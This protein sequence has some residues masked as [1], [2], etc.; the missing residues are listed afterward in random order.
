MQKEVY[1]LDNGKA[2]QVLDIKTN[3]MLYQWSYRDNEKNLIWNIKDSWR[4]LRAN[5]L[6]QDLY[7]E[8]FKCECGK[9]LEIPEKFEARNNKFNGIEFDLKCTCGNVIIVECDTLR[10]KNEVKPNSSHS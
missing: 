4:Q 10:F 1:L 2:I 6:R 3:E 5:F 7:K 9:F 8:L